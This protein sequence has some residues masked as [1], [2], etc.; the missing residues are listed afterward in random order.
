MQKWHANQMAV[1]VTVSAYVYVNVCVYA[2]QTDPC[3]K[4]AAQRKKSGLM[5][6]FLT[7]L[8]FDKGI[9]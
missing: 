5:S 2:E 4:E 1:T 8:F 7:K 6:V 3:T 9:S